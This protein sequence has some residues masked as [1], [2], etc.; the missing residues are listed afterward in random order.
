VATFGR[1][2]TSR[3]SLPL[4]WQIGQSKKSCTAFDEVSTLIAV[5]ERSSGFGGVAGMLPGIER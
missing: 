2:N 3:R 4:S 1:S 5:I